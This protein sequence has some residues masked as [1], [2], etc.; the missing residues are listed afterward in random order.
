MRGEHPMCW[1]PV[2]L[3]RGSS[4]HARGARG[5]GVVGDL[6]AGLIPACAGSTRRCIRPVSRSGAHPRMRGEHEQVDRRSG[7]S[8]GSSPHARGAPGGHSVGEPRPRL[9]PACAGSTSG[10]WRGGKRCRAH[11][12]MRGEHEVAKC[13][14][15]RHGG[16]SP[17]ARGALLC[18]VDRPVRSGLIPACAGSTSP[19][20]TTPPH[21]RAHPR[22]RGEH[23]SVRGDVQAHRGS[24]PHARGAL[25]RARMVRR[26]AG[27][28]PACAGSTWV[29]VMRHFTV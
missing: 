27:L 2:L 7:A 9:I 15:S 12:R 13:G 26:R 21:S 28:I 17:H 14:V 22:M 4:P 5:A 29:V 11:P 18:R 10:C 3:Q 8:K 24:S 1:W 20:P 25:R 16:S 6:A 19:A 23:H